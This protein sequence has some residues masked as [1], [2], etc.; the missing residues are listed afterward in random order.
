MNKPKRKSRN[1]G[2]RPATLEQRPHFA[3]ALEYAMAVINDPKVT[4]YRRDDMAK[5]VLRSTHQASTAEPLGKKAA[6]TIEAQTAHE[7]TEWRGL[8]Q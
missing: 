5:A 4:A 3:T 7:E 6:A 1:L 2:G 8:V